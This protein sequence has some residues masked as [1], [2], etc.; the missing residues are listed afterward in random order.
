MF[1]MCLYLLLLLAVAY[2][3]IRV[4]IRAFR[5]ADLYE[6][7]QGRSERARVM[8]DLAMEMRD[9]AFEVAKKNKDKIK[10]L[11]NSDY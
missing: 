9:D 2:V 6:K 3:V 11:V 1:F 4:G 7:V 8:K 10:K 5:K